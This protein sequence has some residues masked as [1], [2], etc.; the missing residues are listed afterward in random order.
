[1]KINHIILIVET[2]KERALSLV[3]FIYPIRYCYCL[4]H[5]LCHY[6]LHPALS[7]RLLDTVT[8]PAKLL[9]S[10]KQ[11]ICKLT[12]CLF[13]FFFLFFFFVQRLTTITVKPCT[14][15]SFPH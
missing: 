5:H 1:M 14:L 2:G 12:H 3:L 4:P 10:V 8:D 7:P 11:L 15:L 9:Y 6:C 13:P